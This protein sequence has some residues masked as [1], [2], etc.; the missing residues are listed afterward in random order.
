MQHGWK[1]AQPA[2]SSRLDSP[3]EPFMNLMQ[4]EHVAAF[5]LRTRNAA[6]VRVSGTVPA[7]L[8]GKQALPAQVCEN[9]DDVLLRWLERATS[10]LRHAASVSK[11]GAVLL[12]DGPCPG[13]AS[14]HW[15][16]DSMQTACAELGRCWREEAKDVVVLVNG[17]EFPVVQHVPQSMFGRC[18]VGQVLLQQHESGVLYC[19][20]LTVAWSDLVAHAF[21]RCYVESPRGATASAMLAFP[22]AF[23]DAADDSRAIVLVGA[24]RCAADIRHLPCKCEVYSDTS[25]AVSAR[26]SAGSALTVS[27]FEACC[28]ATA[29][30]GISR[31]VLGLP[32]TGRIVMDMQPSGGGACA[33]EGR[34]SSSEGLTLCAKTVLD[35]TP[36]D[37]MVLMHMPE[38]RGLSLHER[39]AADV[40]VSINGVTG[41]VMMRLAVSDILCYERM[42]LSVTVAKDRIDAAPDNVASALAIL[43]TCMKDREAAESALAV[44]PVDAGFNAS[45]VR[46][47]WHALLTTMVQQT[48]A[49]MTSA[50]YPAG[51][52]TMQ[53][54][55]AQACR[56]V[57]S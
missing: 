43:S 28:S 11:Y 52:G 2:A 34:F 37:V 16:R 32:A 39:T 41:M 33:V 18:N 46:L 40:P 19:S 8:S 22:S 48:H 4:V 23:E 25:A 49:R 38:T 3:P 56:Q 53:L 30:V 12:L 31:E 13:E 55:Q 50:L 57:S 45:A 14:S 10:A 9:M 7:T 24:I 5:T 54:P 26:A 36:F 15:T 1:L 42:L 17:G 27:C 47:W 20:P 6:L 29:V 51:F 21:G 35:P 44:T